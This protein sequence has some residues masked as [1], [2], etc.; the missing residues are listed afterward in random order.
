M[1]DYKDLLK[2]E[3]F[4]N[5]FKCDLAILITREGIIDFVKNVI[6]R[7]HRDALNEIPG[8][9]AQ[10]MCNSCKTQDVVPYQVKGVCKKGRGAKFQKV[11]NNGCPKSICNKLA[12]KIISVHKF[13]E[14]SWGNTD[15]TKW[16]TSPWELAK[17]FCPN[18]GYNKVSSAE[19]TDFKGLVSIIQ[20]CDRFDSLLSSTAEDVL[21]NVSRFL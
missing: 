18:D 19:D 9:P 2:K 12:V 4:Q 14:P 15:A 11:S 3:E 20:N 6:N 16:C 13:S 7:F 8:C 10:T 1:T 21:K 5:W 17:C